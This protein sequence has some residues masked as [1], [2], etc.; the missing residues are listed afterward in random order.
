MIRYKTPSHFF[1]SNSH[2][3]YCI[4][5]SGL[6]EKTQFSFTAS[7]SSFTKC[8][9][10]HRIPKQYSFLYNSEYVPDNRKC[11]K[12]AFFTNDNKTTL[13]STTKGDYDFCFCEWNHCT[14]T[15]NGAGICCSVPGSSLSVTD[16]IF[17]FCYAS[18]DG[19]GA[20]ISSASKIFFEQC[21]FLSGSALSSGGE[22]GGAGIC[23]KSITNDVWIS[24]CLFFSGRVNDDGAGILFASCV[25]QHSLIC[26]SCRYICGRTLSTTS[27]AGGGFR[28]TRPSPIPSISDCLFAFNEGH[29]RAGACDLDVS[30]NECTDLIRFCF[31]YSNTAPKASDVCLPCADG[32]P[33][34]NPFAHSFTLGSSEPSVGW[35]RDYSSITPYDSDWLPLT[36]VSLSFTESLTNSYRYTSHSHNEYKQK[37]KKVTYTLFSS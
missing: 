37:E 19:G 33:T 31:F 8:V 29:Q 10:N 22:N 32:V 2:S 18:E 30:K 17:S 16:S 24:S 20:Y 15:N 1:L 34:T 25:S 5:C 26:A 12:G 27:S 23:G 3:V 9:R 7:N 28:F 13:P 11:W 21:S 14:T 4:L 6:T 35:T 36:T